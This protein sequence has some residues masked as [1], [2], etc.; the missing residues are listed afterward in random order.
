M[1]GESGSLQAEEAGGSPRQ[2]SEAPHLES[3]GKGQKEIAEGRCSHAV[4]RT[5]TSHRDKGSW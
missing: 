1:A 2:G 3:S 5:E 4:P